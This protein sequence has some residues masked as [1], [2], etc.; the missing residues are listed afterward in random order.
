MQRRAS[1]LMQATTPNFWAEPPASGGLWV[2]LLIALVLGFA[3]LAGLSAI[4]P[5]LRRHVVAIVT[6][7]AGLYWVLLYVWPTPVDWVKG[8]KATGPIDGVGIWLQEANGPIVSFTQILTS[9]LIGLGIYSLLRVHIKRLIGFK[10]DWFF[11]FTLLLSML[12][13]IIFGYADWIQRLDPVNGPK[14]ELQSNWGPA[15]FARDFL[16]EGLLQQMDA[17]MFSVIA[18][19]ILSAAYRAFR[20]RSVEATILLATA[21]VVMISLMGAISQGFDG[22]IRNQAGE[23]GFLLNFQLATIA[24]WLKDTFQTSSIRGIQFGVGIGALAMGLR[25]WLS[26]E[27]TGGSR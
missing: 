4:P 1:L 6:F 10:T 18:F 23:N 19:Y 13:I 21:L 3:F 16:F 20:I 27:R 2:K 22:F 8:E 24:A 5:Q 14:L 15:Q 26:L 17:A 25:L 12:A 9:F 11:S 7:V